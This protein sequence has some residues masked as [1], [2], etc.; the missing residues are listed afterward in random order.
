MTR[1]IHRRIVSWSWTSFGAFIAHDRLQQLF[2]VLEDRIPQH[3]TDQVVVILPL[4]RDYEQLG[5]TAL[6]TEQ[7]GL[8]EMAEQVAS[9]GYGVRELVR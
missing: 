7:R 9:K 4:A 1:T 8:Q 5:R 6:K 3:P 2:D